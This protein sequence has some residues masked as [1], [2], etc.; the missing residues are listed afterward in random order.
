MK[1]EPLT[2]LA[3]GDIILELPNAEF[4][5]ALVAP[6]LQSGEVV[7]GQGEVMFT[8]RGID[9][10]PEFF[11]S[12]GCPPGNMSALAAAGFNVITLA[13]NHVWDRGAPGIEDS[14]K[15]L[16]KY[17]IAVTGA[18][19]NIDEAREPAVVE[20]N[21][22]RFGFLNYNC[23]GVTGQWATK[24]KPGCAYV[25]II[26]HYE[27]NG[28][29]PGGPPD[30]YTFAEP[31]T[32]QAIVDDIQKLKPLCDILSVA[33]HM[34]VLHSPEIAMYERQVS[35]AA[36]EAGADLILGHHAHYLK[37]VEIYKGKGIFHGLGQFVPAIKGLTNEQWKEMYSLSAPKVRVG[38]NHQQDPDQYRTMIA[39]CT[40][41]DGKISQVGY[42]PCL[43]NAQ[44]QP[45]VLKNDERGQGAFDFMEKITKGEGLNTRYEWKGDEIVIRA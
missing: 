7:V 27:M 25:R 20:R 38:H 44:R 45:E 26:S 4:Y 11:P 12:P 8:S 23:V 42:L 29:D 9:T 30:V 36:I 41:E 18:G 13:G 2:M 32:L 10:F 22:T 19:M 14:V 21:G 1:G 17:G 43:I 6:V 3:V 39:K 16:R 33:F 5:L 15:G 37:G 34:G 40:I 24:A 28:S 31:R 35:Y